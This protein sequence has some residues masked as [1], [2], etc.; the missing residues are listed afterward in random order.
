MWFVK[1][2]QHTYTPLSLTVGSV[3]S[4]LWSGDVVP[5]STS[6]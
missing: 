4:S 5:E 2:M 3:Y 1:Y 6:W